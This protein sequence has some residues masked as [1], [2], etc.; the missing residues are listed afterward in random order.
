MVASGL[1]AAA[2]GFLKIIMDPAPGSQNGYLPAGNLY[3]FTLHD[4]AGNRVD[5]S[6]LITIGVPYKQV[7]VAG[8]GIDPAQLVLLRGGAV[9][10]ATTSQE[11]AV[12]TAA[13]AA[14]SEFVVAFP[15][16]P[17]TAKPHPLPLIE[18]DFDGYADAPKILDPSGNE[19]ADPARGIGTVQVGE[20]V[21]LRA[22]PRDV[23][24]YAY[25]S[26]A[27]ELLARPPGS[28]AEFSGAGER[29][30]LI[31]DRLGMYELRLTAVS[32]VTSD[33]EIIVIT[34]GGYSYVNQ[35]GEISNYCISC[36]AGNLDGFQ[37]I[38]DSYGRAVLRDL[39]TPWEQSSHARAYATVVQEA[40]EDNTV[41]LNCHTTG[42]LFAD[43]STPPDGTDDYPAAWGFD[44]FITDW[45]TPAAAA[46][47]APHLKGV[48]C[49][50]CHG[51]GGAGDGAGLQHFYRS[52]LGQGPCMACHNIDPD[53]QI[54]GRS[55]F[56]GW[57]GD[58]HIEAHRV[59]D[60]RSR[61]AD[62]YPCYHCHVGQ[63]FIGRMH[64]K[65]LAPADVKRP[66]GITCA[67]CHDP[68]GESGN[69]AQLRITGEV[70][71]RLKNNSVEDDFSELTFA[72][73]N[74]AVCYSCH[75]AYIMLPA[76]GEDLHGNQAEMMEGVGGYAYGLEV[77]T[78]T[79]GGRVVGD[80]CVEC[81]MVAEHGGEAV[82]THQ[83]R[84]YEGDD[85]FAATGYTTK[86]CST[87]ECHQGAYALPTGNRFD[88]GGRVTAIKERLEELQTR[89]NHLA[90][91]E[92]PDS[93]IIHN[94][95]QSLAGDKLAAVN[96]A[97]YNYLFVKRDGS[98]GVHN[99]PYA[100]ELLRLSLED[101]ESY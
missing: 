33:S 100:A 93:P 84:L 10:G 76:V 60:G 49:E 9:V 1:E 72:A 8:A 30:E 69:V 31:P 6:G 86:G 75:N 101:L 97:A 55:Y 48:N 70:T 7:V 56:Y 51:P 47:A 87:Q 41:C 17:P 5:G 63:Y 90:G 46:E 81:H 28:T 13:V 52:S 2:G 35:G 98:Y 36:H 54:P 4:G 12:L 61:M 3:T 15:E 67:V 21:A 14:F 95:E 68:H 82:V 99:Y 59:Q 64:G 37:H 32:Y 29:V 94:Y 11:Q 58:L 40:G 44:D 18:L 45:N 57:E 23:S 25:D 89:I 34:V 85:I 20:R 26:F 78:R 77:G 38:K 66:E 74:A 19:I 80:K 91:R 83:R 71:I 53:Q 27:W 39:V 88:Y 96:R 50:S 73:G 79:H 24:G 43:R 16:I 62:S 65:T 92:D 22:R 42:F